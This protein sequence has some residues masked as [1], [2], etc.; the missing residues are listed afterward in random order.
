M[1]KSGGVTTLIHSVTDMDGKS[2]S[3][4]LCGSIVK[5]QRIRLSG[6]ERYLLDFE[7]TQSITW[8]FE[9]NTGKVRFS[10]SG[11]SRSPAHNPI[12]TH[13]L[14][15]RAAVRNQHLQALS[16]RRPLL[17]G[18][19]HLGRHHHRR[20]NKLNQ[21]HPHPEPQRQH[22]PRIDPPSGLAPRTASPL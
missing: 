13:K 18:N 14:T 22:Y 7:G 21:L 6:L 9:K 15:S 2:H 5:E 19:R 10:S 8:L 4:K 12:S 11:I 3:H 17:V 20:S 1:A 16:I